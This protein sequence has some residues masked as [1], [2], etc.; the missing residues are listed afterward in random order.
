MIVTDEIYN[1]II[2]MF[3]DAKNK[4]IPYMDLSSDELVTK[5]HSL[6][7]HIDVCNLMKRLMTKDDFCIDERIEQDNILLKIRYYLKDK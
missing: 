7:Q 3:L 4:G 2:E 1:F 6:D 5:F